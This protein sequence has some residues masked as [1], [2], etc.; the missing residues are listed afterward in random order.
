MTTTRVW[1]GSRAGWLAI[2]PLRP[3]CDATVTGRADGVVGTGE[4][5]HPWSGS[6]RAFADVEALAHSGVEKLRLAVSPREPSAIDTIDDR[7]FHPGS[8]IGDMV[9][10]SIEHPY[11][12]ALECPDPVPA[13]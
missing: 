2:R 9:N 12:R 10:G 8:F 5:G 6:R 3:T 11:K 4:Q 13:G 7:L 1:H